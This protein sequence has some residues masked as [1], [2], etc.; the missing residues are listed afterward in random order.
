VP[1]LILGSRQSRSAIDG[2]CPVKIGIR[3][4]QAG[5]IAEGPK[6]EVAS[7]PLAR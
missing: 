7:T 2:P 6:F 4:H 3:G 1:F 5:A